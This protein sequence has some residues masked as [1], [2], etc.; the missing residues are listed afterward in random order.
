VSGYVTYAAVLVRLMASGA[1]KS[2]QAHPGRVAREH[3]QGQAPVGLPAQ[4]R[5][6][7]RRVVPARAD[8]A[9]TAKATTS[10]VV[11]LREGWQGARREGERER[12]GRGERGRGGEG[13]REERE[14]RGAK[15]HERF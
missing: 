9:S 3:G 4:A 2:T 7:S 10:W 12:E 13:E 5:A 6:A 14:E 1:S 8:P 11:Q 15:W